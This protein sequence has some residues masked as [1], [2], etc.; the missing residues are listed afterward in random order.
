MKRF[1]VILLAGLMAIIFTSC[2]KNVED[3]SDTVAENIEMLEI[4]EPELIQMQKICNLAVMECYYH[5]VTSYHLEDAE[6]FLW[7]KK[8]L[9]FWIEYDAI[10]TLGLDSEKLKMELNGD[11]VKI[12]LPPAELQKCE[13]TTTDLN[14]ADFYTSKNSAKATMEDGKKALI[15]AQAELEDEVKNDANLLSAA[16][17]RAKT[18]LSEYITNIGKTVGKNYKIEWIELN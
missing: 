15:A 8:D 5:N 3:S 4:A 2:A 7:I 12:E 14:N 9:D 11:K 18:V 16:R 13:I 6:N 10:V 17:D 1:L